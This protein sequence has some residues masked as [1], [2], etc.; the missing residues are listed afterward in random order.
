M[1]GGSQHGLLFWGVLDIDP[2][3]LSDF[4]LF[5]E[6]PNDSVDPEAVALSLRLPQWERAVGSSTRDFQM[7]CSC[8][9]G[10]RVAGGQV[11][12]ASLPNGPALWLRVCQRR[13]GRPGF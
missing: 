4:A 13:V 3:G 5:P 2:G 8:G 1:V 9:V 11:S 6:S 10:G 12:S 7:E